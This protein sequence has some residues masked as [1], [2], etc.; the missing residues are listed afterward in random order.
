VVTP[1]FK[2][3]FLFDVSCHWG[4][5][6]GGGG[7]LHS[8][9]LHTCLM[10]RKYIVFGR[11]QRSLNMCTPQSTELGVRALAPR[12]D[13]NVSLVMLLVLILHMFDAK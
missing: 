12:T 2:M 10:L 3:F 4:G 1:S 8:M 5:M 9:H 11:C 13:A 6:G 7:Y